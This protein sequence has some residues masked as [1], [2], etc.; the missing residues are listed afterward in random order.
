MQTLALIATFII[1]LGVA[2]VAW[3]VRDRRRGLGFY[4]CWGF[5]VLG[6]AAIAMG[7]VWMIPPAVTAW[8]MLQ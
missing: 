4:D 3:Y 8:D 1:V 7:A 5:L 2:S 6:V